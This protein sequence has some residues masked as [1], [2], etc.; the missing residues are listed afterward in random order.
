MESTLASGKDWLETPAIE[1]GANGRS[2]AVGGMS[3][4]LNLPPENF[5]LNLRSVY[6]G[7]HLRERLP[8]CTFA[9]NRI[10]IASG[11]PLSLARPG[12]SHGLVRAPQTF[13]L[14]PVLFNLN[15]SVQ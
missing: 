15:N 10:S 12:T 8:L 9:P 3:H 6:L 4:L 5:D 1:L 2:I 13:E 14:A 11:S 7:N